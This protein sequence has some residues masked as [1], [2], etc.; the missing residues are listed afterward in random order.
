LAPAGEPF[1]HIQRFFRKSGEEP[2]RPLDKAGPRHEGV[3]RWVSCGLDHAGEAEIRSNL[4][5][6]LARNSYCCAGGSWASDFRRSASRILR[7]CDST[8]GSLWMKRWFIPLNSE[9]GAAHNRFD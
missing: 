1:R 6:H 3:D 2:A 5:V 7:P 9:M 8:T 4:S